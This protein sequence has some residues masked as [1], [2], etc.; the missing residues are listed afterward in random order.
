MQEFQ[1]KYLVNFRR[2]ISVPAD[3]ALH[4]R[5]ER[6]PLEIRAGKRSGVEED[7]TNVPSQR[8]LVPKAEM[9]ELMSA[10]DK[11]FQVERRQEVIDLR[12]PLRH[13]VVVRVF[14]LEREIEDPA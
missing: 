8:S 1:S 13:A 10:E 7:L 4:H 9:L 3:M 12:Y 5:F 11:A 2:V 14:G 6:L